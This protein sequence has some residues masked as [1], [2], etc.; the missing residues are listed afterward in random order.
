M[1]LF[2]KDDGVRRHIIR[3]RDALA[4]QNIGPLGHFMGSLVALQGEHKTDDGHLRC[5]SCGRPRFG[6]HFSTTSSHFV[7]D[8]VNGVHARFRISC[9][10]PD[11]GVRLFSRDAGQLVKSLVVQHHTHGDSKLDGL[12]TPARLRPPSCTSS[13]RSLAP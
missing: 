4:N 3:E 9:N 8:A 12:L 1:T 5:G 13:R 11:H 2:S 7:S 10:L 6:V